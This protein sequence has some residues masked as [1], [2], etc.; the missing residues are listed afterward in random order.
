MLFYSNLGTGWGGGQPNIVNNGGGERIVWTGKRFSGLFLS[1]NPSASYH[2]ILF[3]IVPLLQGLQTGGV[4]SN[5][6]I[7]REAPGDIT[8]CTPPRWAGGR[9]QWYRRG[10]VPKVDTQAGGGKNRERE[11]GGGSRERAKQ[12]GVL[13]RWWSWWIFWR[14]E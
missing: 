3:S 11:G 8:R 1:S 9:G 6:L 2:S 12:S 5:A 13:R 10:Q 7:G 14:K 4:E